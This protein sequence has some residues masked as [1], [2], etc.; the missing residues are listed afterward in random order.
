MNS[1]ILRIILEEAQQYKEGKELLE[2]IKIDD[3]GLLMIYQN[4]PKSDIFYK[5][6]ELLSKDDKSKIWEM[7]M[8]F[9]E[10]ILEDDGYLDLTESQVG[11]KK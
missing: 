11:V 4:T 9:H 2:H 6:Y 1:E 5:L 3:Q 8:N 7:L 10:A